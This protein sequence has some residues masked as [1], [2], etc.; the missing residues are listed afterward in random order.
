M[1]NLLKQ[2]LIKNINKILKLKNQDQLSKIKRKDCN[3]WDSLNH[4]KIIFLIEK[5]I[6]NKI[7]INK[8]NKISTG[9]ELIKIISNI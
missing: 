1:K 9:K 3:N 8:L 2:N 7:S 6:K 4:L 5:N